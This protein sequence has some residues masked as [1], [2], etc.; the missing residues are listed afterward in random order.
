MD[1][2]TADLEDLIGREWLTVNGIGGY[3]SST[4]PGMNTRKYHGLLVAAMSPP[5][6]RMV[7]LSRVEETVYHNGWPFALACNEYPGAI[8]PVGYEV[9]KA[10]S[11]DPVPR[12][13]YQADGWT[14]EKQV[15]LLEG[16]N[17]V[18]LSYTLLGADRSADL[19]LRPL[20]ALRPIH[21]LM[22]Q[23]NGRLGAEVH[24]SGCLRIP[25]SSR[26]PEVFFAHDGK[27]DG[28][29]HWY[30]NTIYRREQERGYG[31]LEDLWS[32]GVVRW[33][34]S[35][36]QT[37]H[38]VCSA[39]PVELG[40]VVS[41]KGRQGARRPAAAAASAEEGWDEL[42]RG[43]GQFVVRGEVG[44]ESA[45]VVTGYPWPA[46]SGRDALIGFTGLFLIPGRAAEARALLTSMARQM[47]GG[48]MPSEFVENGGAAVYGGAD[49]SLWW[50]HAARQYAKYSGYEGSSDELLD[51]LDEIIR[52]YRN[53]TELGI[54]VDW[55]GL[56]V[57]TSDDVGASWMDAK[58]AGEVITPRRGRPVELN[59]LWYN[60]LRVAAEWSGRAG[61]D[62]QAAEY[63]ILAGTVKAAFNRR[64][65]N[66]EQGCCFDVVADDGADAS[67]RP[68]Q[69]LAVSLPYPVLDVARHAAVV[70]KA[71]GELLTPL[72]VRTL[73]PKDSRYQGRY[74][75]NVESRDRA[76]H[77]GAAYPW[78]LGPLVTAYV[79]INGR[80]EK[81]LGTGRE[82]IAGCLGYLRRQG[83]GQICE[84]FDGDA[85]HRP[86][87]AVASAR[88]IAEILRCYAE[89]IL[90]AG[91]APEAE[92][93][94]G[95]SVSA[96]ARR[97]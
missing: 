78:L 73:S 70:E 84:L 79:R 77:M 58:T 43:A 62:E 91:P 56:L 16:E 33:T 6:R 66:E 44:N 3:A 25:P 49:V 8:H 39:D 37:V 32:P 96:P 40:R 9:L 69:L 90:D 92:P 30:L 4:V 87:G 35:P 85:P 15:C 11:H 48:L 67:V 1:F 81:A 27:F 65:W 17:T 75:G 88:S 45:R 13:A 95:T 26:T 54:G 52:S 93:T 20:F 7:L 55:D 59:A 10:F 23:W 5:V 47:R 34:L 41:E 80:G 21:E 72:G 97:V 83:M 24:P 94:S 19:E 76:Y 28:E 50:A 14:L 36:G 53:G 61:R 86:G 31:G 63:S 64:F 2:A 51:V 71:R 68:N 12:W 29:A 74:L 42:V 22:Y 46:P 18:V 38:F 57:A 89:D 60:A 82:M